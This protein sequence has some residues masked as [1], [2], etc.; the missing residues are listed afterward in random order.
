M[1]RHLASL[2]FGRA[3]RDPRSQTDELSRESV[4]ERANAGPICPP[5]LKQRLQKK[6]S[7]QQPECWGLFRFVDWLARRLNVDHF[8]AV[9]EPLKGRD[10][11]D[12][13]REDLAPLREALVGAEQYGLLRVV[14]PTDDLE[15]LV[16][17]VSRRSYRTGAHRNCVGHCSCLR[18]SVSVCPCVRHARSTREP[19]QP[20][21]AIVLASYCASSASHVC[22]W[23]NNFIAKAVPAYPIIPP[24]VAPIG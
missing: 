17:V 8:G 5:R 23:E 16:G 19:P 24:A 6:Q 1:Q 14:A 4:A 7:R 3:K 10:D 2:Q 18:H 13:V 22:C 12:C 15:E 20:R 9:D 21:R 11:A